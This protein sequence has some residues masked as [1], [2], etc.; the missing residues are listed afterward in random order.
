MNHVNKTLAIN[1]ITTKMTV[2]NKNEGKRFPSV[3]RFYI[4]LCSIIFLI[5]HLLKN[6]D[7]YWSSSCE[8]QS[9][10]QLPVPW[11]ILMVAIAGHKT[12][13]LINLF[14]NWCSSQACV[15]DKHSDYSF[16]CWLVLRRLLKI[17]AKSAT[18]APVFASTVQWDP[19]IRTQKKLAKASVRFKGVSLKRSSTV[20]MRFSPK[21]SKRLWLFAY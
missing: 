3:R 21:R 19:L 11:E 1:L 15:K 14:Y 20:Y 4:Y 6:I 5:A 9:T 16:C 7:S 2:V 17:S 13:L 8:S 10:G 12:N 18:R